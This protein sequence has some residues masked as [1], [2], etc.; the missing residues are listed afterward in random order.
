MALKLHLDDPATAAPAVESL[1][2]RMAAEG[3]AGRKGPITFV[4]TLEDGGEAE[5]GFD[6]SEGWPL[7]PQIKSALKSLPG[8]M[9]VEEI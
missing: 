3:V 2:S 1:L 8:V 5:L 9:A 4:V 6:R 7:N